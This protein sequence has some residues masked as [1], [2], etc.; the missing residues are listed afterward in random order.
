ME[1]SLQHLTNGPGNRICSKRDEDQPG[2]RAPGPDPF[3]SG[4][5]G[6]VEL[7][8]QVLAGSPSQSQAGQRWV[9]ANRCW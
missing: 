9:D 4:Q 2:A 1:R 5:F 7:C 8:K 3:W 6:T